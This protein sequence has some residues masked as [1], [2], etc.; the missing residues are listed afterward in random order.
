MATTATMVQ[1]EHVPRDATVVD[2]RTGRWAG[3][4][5]A[6]MVRIASYFGSWFRVPYDDETFSGSGAMTVTVEQ[7]D[8]VTLQY[9]LMG[10]RLEVFFVLRGIS[11]GGT[12]D[13]SIQIAIP[14]RNDRAQPFTAGVDVT[15]P[16]RISD[17]G[18]AAIGLARVSAGGQ[19]IKIQKVNG[20]N[21]SAS[22]GAT[23]V[24]GVIPMEVF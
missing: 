4:W 13:T 16:C 3:K 23:D 10:K 2:I 21:W 6:L 5:G 22:A 12:P 7:A 19:V 8:Q 24:E 1:G 11:I 9:G 17:N 20:A 18:T 14:G 15:V